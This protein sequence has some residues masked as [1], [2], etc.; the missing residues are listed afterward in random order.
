VKVKK[1]VYLLAALFL[2]PLKSYATQIELVGFHLGSEYFILTEEINTDDFQARQI[3][4]VIKCTFAEG[5]IS[6][7]EED[8]IRIRVMPEGSSAGIQYSSEDLRVLVTEII[9]DR[10][11]LIQISCPYDVNVLGPKVKLNGEVRVI[12]EE[13]EKQS[14]PIPLTMDPGTT[15]DLE[16]LPIMLSGI[17]VPKQSNNP[18]AVTFR[19]TISNT[20]RNYAVRFFDEKMQPIS[21]ERSDYVI[22][23]IH[24]AT[25]L[26]SRRAEK[27]YASFRYV[28]VSKSELVRFS[29]DANLGVVSLSK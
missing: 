23:N 4:F 11:C 29:L 16:G 17:E 10:T 24:E 27:L 26:L 13:K 18:L 21:T 14:R 6:G 19:T 22:D 20:V 1:Y 8:S 12:L 2:L 28:G 9:S 3:I 7:I 25:Y 5:Q 15:I